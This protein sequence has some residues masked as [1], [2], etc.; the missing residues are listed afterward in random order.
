MIF[1][2]AHY[3]NSAQWINEEYARRVSEEKFVADMMGVPFWL[4]VPDKAA[5]LRK[6]WRIMNGHP[7]QPA[8]AP[9][10]APVETPAEQVADKPPGK[11][12]K[13]AA[14]SDGA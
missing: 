5:E 13:R 9:A 1:T 3:P 7:V 14:E 6:A 12:K 2:P 8:D 11:A 10:D 4:D